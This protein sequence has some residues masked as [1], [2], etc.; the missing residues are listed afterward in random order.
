[1]PQH[2]PRDPGEITGFGGRARSI[3]VPNSAVEGRKLLP[4]G[5]RFVPGFSRHVHG[6][7]SRIPV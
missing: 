1:M 6:P 4:H 5:F 3:P 2:T 7:M